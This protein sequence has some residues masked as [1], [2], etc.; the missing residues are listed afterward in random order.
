MLE[1]INNIILFPFWLV[2]TFFVYGFGILAYYGL[3]HIIKFYWEK[4]S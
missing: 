4:R 2:S 1:L 3:Y